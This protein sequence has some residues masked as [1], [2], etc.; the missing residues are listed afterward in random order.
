M[1]KKYGRDTRTRWEGVYARHAV[2]CPVEGLPRNPTLTQISRACKC[3]PSYWGKVYDRADGKYKKT[4]MCPTSSAARHARKALLELLEKGGLPKEAPLRL[5]DALPRFVE[6][7]EA[8]RALNKKG[9]P[10]KPRAIKSIDQTIRLHFMPTLGPRRITDIRKGDIQRIADNVS[11][12][13]SGSRV[14]GVV[15]AM[16]SLFTWA[17]QREYASHEPAEEI[18]LPP[19]EEKPRER[20]AT[21]KEMVALLGALETKDAVPYALAAYSWGRRSQ[22]ERL[23]WAEVDLQAGLVEWGADEQNARKSDAAK[24]VVPLLRPVWTLLRE[25]WIEQGRPAGDQLVCPPI[26]KDTKRGLLSMDGVADRAAKEWEKTEPKLAPIGL[27]ECRHTAASWL[28]PAGVSPKTASILMGHSI[29]D[30]QPG[31]AAI[32]LARYTHLMPDAMEIARKQMDEWIVAQIAR[33]T[34][35]E[36]AAAGE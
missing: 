5:R 11:E 22:I 29:P 19:V 32:T 7:A 28:D 15:N 34:E 17:N 8:G 20:I 23:R 2:G 10:F 21:P 33:E 9:K 24:H 4:K 6:D 12:Q 35:A 36:Q 18:V 25:A 14:R 26:N 3:E 31:A 30:R 16:R 13:L 1:K 27:Q